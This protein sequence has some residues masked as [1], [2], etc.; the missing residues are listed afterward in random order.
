V[1]IKPVFTA[2]SMISKGP[3]SSAVS[4]VVTLM[5]SEVSRRS[6]RVVSGIGK[7]FHGDVD[8]LEGPHVLGRVHRGDV[9]GQRGQP[10]L[11][12]GRLGYREVAVPGLVH[13]TGERDVEAQLDDL[14]VRAEHLG[15]DLHDPRVG[16]QVGEATNLLR[17]HLDIPPLV[18]RLLPGHG[19]APATGSPR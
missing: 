16:G 8:D 15:R 18:A 3:M 17:V 12:P 2:M 5:A 9:D 19:S 4:T 1:T 7:S 10:A 6:V 11:G 13:R 14:V